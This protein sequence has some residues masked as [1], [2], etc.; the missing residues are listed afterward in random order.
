M[1]TEPMDISAVQF[2]MRDLLRRTQ[3]IE[4]VRRGEIVRITPAFLV[5][6]ESLRCSLKSEKVAYGGLRIVSGPLDKLHQ[7]AILPDE[8]HRLVDRT[9]RVLARNTPNEIVFEDEIGGIFTYPLL[10]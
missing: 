3:V 9:V 10:P 4:A 2:V 6:G 1:N 5:N 8:V 7:A